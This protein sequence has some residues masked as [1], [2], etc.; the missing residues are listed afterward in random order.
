MLFCTA[1]LYFG[2]GSIA[3]A[4]NK[5]IDKS[6][7]QPKLASLNPDL[8]LID[9]YKTLAS[10]QPQQAQNKVDELLAV[11]PNFQLG[12]L[13]RGDLIAMRTRA[14]DHFG[15]VR[16][17]PNDKLKDLHEEAIAR[18]RAITEKP[19]PEL[20]PANLIQMAADQRYAILIDAKRARLYL[21]ENINGIPNLVIDYYVTHG[22]LGI[23]KFKEGDQ[24][25]PLGVYFIT[26]RLPGTKLPD[27]YGPG[28][29]PLSYPNEWD[30]YQGRGGSGI[31]LH[32]V[33][34]S[35]YSRPPLASDGCVVLSNP[36]FLKI[37]GMV[38]IGKTPVIITEQLNF[39]NRNAWANEKQQSKKILD[40][41]LQDYASGNINLQLRH[42]SKKF[43]ASNN[44]T[45]ASWLQ[46]QNNGLSNSV[47]IRDIS[48]FKYPSRD[49]MMVMIFTQEI[50][51]AK[52][53][54][55]FKRK[56]Y[57]TKES[58]Q[59]HIV[60]EEQNQI[61]GNKLETEHSKTEIVK[62]ETPKPESV[63]T[64]P[65]KTSVSKSTASL[66]QAATSQNDVLKSVD[67]WVSAWTNKNTNAYLA[68][69]ARDF[70][71]PNGESRKSWAEERRS[72]ID[73][74]GKISVKLEKPTVNIEGNIAT[75]K[76][77]QNYQSGSL[78]ASSRKT[79]IMVKQDGKWLIKQERTGS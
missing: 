74:K 28:A 55:I 48:Q 13:I 16:N 59:W 75:V 30:K 47:H 70:Q 3:I 73:G 51:G 38:D 9:I 67:H 61:S 50:N 18:I 32:G 1:F 44:D 6:A 72:R 68:H 23:D 19:L 4:N 31:W 12:H 26:N 60:F 79:L 78:T 21:Y 7:P 5:A 65:A 33:P 15:A 29:L 40:D 36:D 24:R 57:W 34:A 27:F 58:N 41:W 22:K 63:K 2:S 25:T 71:T 76:F 53:T 17:A 69:Y 20:I 66:K 64:E 54:S 46:K 39:F 62:I 49:E 37:A 56:Q 35:N 10:N 77:R 14:V 45:A 8:A 43:K 42:Y 52:G 11:Y